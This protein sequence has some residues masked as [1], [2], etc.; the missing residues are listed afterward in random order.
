MSGMIRHNALAR[1]RD[2]KT[3]A[4]AVCLTALHACTPD[5]PTLDEVRAATERYRNVEVAL[6]DGYVR[7]P[8]DVC[9]TPYSLGIFENLGVMGVH[10]LRLDLLGIDEDATRLDATG[11]HTDFL[12]PAV[13]VYE[14]QPDSSLV[15]VA[16]SNTV[17]AAAWEAA[18][19]RR[20][21]TF[22]D[23]PFAFAPDNPGQDS[24]RITTCTSGSSWRTR[25]A[26]SRPTTPPRV[27]ST[28][29]SACR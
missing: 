7:D 19:H 9:E 2:P 28:T 25:A 10:Y 5:A 11:T 20:P 18:G 23:V 4:M 21:P 29:H 8:L 15:L 26:C 13:L 6:A 24:R 27:A 14:P 17:S 3:I 22:G 1:M 12:Q 16:I